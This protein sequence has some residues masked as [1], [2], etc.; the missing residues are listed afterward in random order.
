MKS[1]ARAACSVALT[2]LFTASACYSAYMALFCAWVTAT[3]VTGESRERY[4]AW[5]NI[6]GL[7]CIASTA[8]AIATIVIARRV[9]HK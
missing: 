5:A 8:A 7:A 6:F 4:A 3:P 2:A 1:Y 9:W